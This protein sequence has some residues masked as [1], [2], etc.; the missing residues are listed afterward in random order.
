MKNTII[1]EIGGAKVTIVFAEEDNPETKKNLLW[2]LLQC[3]EDKIL[4]Q[5]TENSSDTPV[6]CKI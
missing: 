5:T 2:Y 3:Y 1:R 4:S 6:A